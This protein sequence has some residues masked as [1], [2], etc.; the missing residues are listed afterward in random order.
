MQCPPDWDGPAG[1]VAGGNMEPPACQIH[2]RLKIG[3][4][5]LMRNLI[6][7]NRGHLPA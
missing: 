2:N 7:F 6:P 1:A 5:R 3:R 4:D